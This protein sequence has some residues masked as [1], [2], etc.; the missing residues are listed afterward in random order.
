QKIDTQN[1]K[2]ASLEQKVSEQEAFLELMKDPAISVANLAD[3]KGGKSTAKVYW[4]SVTKK[5]M[6]VVSNLQAVPK[7]KG[8]SLELWTFCGDKPPVATKL[9]WTEDRKSTRLN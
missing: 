2:F 5:G 9:F 4:H 3:P 6:V 7:G 1:V 8:T